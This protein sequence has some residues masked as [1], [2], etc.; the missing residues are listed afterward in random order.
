MR[1]LRFLGKFNIDTNRHV[2]EELKPWRLA[3]ASG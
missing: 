1:Y 2:R 3:K